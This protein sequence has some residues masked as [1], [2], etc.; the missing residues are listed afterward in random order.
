MLADYLLNR[1]VDRLR[2]RP[3]NPTRDA[4]SPAALALVEEF[5]S[6]LVCLYPPS[7]RRIGP[8]KRRLEALKNLMREPRKA[9]DPKFLTALYTVDD[10][11]PEESL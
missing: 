7:D 10:S 4:S 9:R 11:R 2:N 6:V 1:K 3:S 5:E 8:V